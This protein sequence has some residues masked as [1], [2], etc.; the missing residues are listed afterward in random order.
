M[1]N[2]ERVANIILGLLFIRIKRE[3]TPI[4]QLGMPVK[5]RN[6]PLALKVNIEKV[7]RHTISQSS[8]F[9][10]KGFNKITIFEARYNIDGSIK[11]IS[12]IIP[13]I[14]SGITFY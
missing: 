12:A 3:S 1:C 8:I 9:D 7:T 5:I 2:S 14:D 4:M 10:I 6:I 11:E 13:R